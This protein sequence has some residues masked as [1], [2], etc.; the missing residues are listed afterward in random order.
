MKG[1]GI[2]LVLLSI[3]LASGC[4]SASESDR[5]VQLWNGRDFEGWRLFLEGRNVDVDDVWSVR[6]GVIRCEGKPNGYMRTTKS[7]ADYHLHVEWRWPEQP[8]NSGVL[9]HCRLPDRVWPLCIESQLQSGS[10]GDFWVLSHSGITADGKRY[11]DLKN[12]YVHVK[13]KHDSSENPPGQWNVY[14]IYCRGDTIRS[15]VN[16]VEQNYGTE[17]TPSSGY[18]ALQSEGSPIEFRNIYIVPLK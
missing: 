8:T 4:K 9:L 17:A 12:P 1:V 3:L 6:D 18:I 16:G 10:A 15:V 7:Y 11:H 2:D 13:K 14:D 5:R